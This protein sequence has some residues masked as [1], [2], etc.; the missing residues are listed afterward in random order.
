MAF[1]GTLLIKIKTSVILCLLIAVAL[2]GVYAKVLYIHYNKTHITEETATLLELCDEHLQPNPYTASD[3]PDIYEG[4][5]I[6]VPQ[7]QWHMVA[8]SE[9][10]PFYRAEVN[11]SILVANAASWLRPIL[12][13]FELYDIEDVCYI[14]VYYRTSRT[15]WIYAVYRYADQ[16]VSQMDVPAINISWL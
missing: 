16:K 1:G 14:K 3:Y 4:K 12:G 8:Y 6:G 10:M 7:E 9:R 5:L 2:L 15:S 11:S 13:Y